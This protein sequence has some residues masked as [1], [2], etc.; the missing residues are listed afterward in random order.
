M[1]KS[2]G[3]D[4]EKAIHCQNCNYFEIWDKDNDSSL[5]Y[6]KK[7]NCKKLHCV[8]CHIFLD[9]PADDDIEDDDLA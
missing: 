2:K 3:S 5:F 8:I 4:L 6:C 7:S 1:Y 9:E